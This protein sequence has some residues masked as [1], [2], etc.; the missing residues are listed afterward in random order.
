MKPYEALG[1]QA[2]QLSDIWW[3]VELTAGLQDWCW[4]STAAKYDKL[5]YL[6]CVQ[7][8]VFNLDSSCLEFSKHFK[9]F[10]TFKVTFICHSVL[11]LLICGPHTERIPLWSA[12]F[13]LRMTSLII[14]FIWF[15]EVCCID[16]SQTV[17]LNTSLCWIS[18]YSFFFFFVSIASLSVAVWEKTWNLQPV[19]KTRND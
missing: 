6:I 3:L 14:S 9:V 1:L 12:G 10:M 4:S 5:I 16:T 11:L 17:P 19:D 13:Y 15:F 7:R 8:H 18:K 2:Q